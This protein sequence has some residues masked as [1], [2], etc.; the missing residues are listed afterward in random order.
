MISVSFC[1]LGFLK[2]SVGVWRGVI[3]MAH[4][5]RKTK[6]QMKSLCKGL[7]PCSSVCV[8]GVSRVKSA[9]DGSMS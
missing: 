8:D 5:N 9:F 2:K 1:S 3:L 4:S 6:E 7:Q